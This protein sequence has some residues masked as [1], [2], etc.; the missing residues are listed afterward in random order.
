MTDVV[1]CRSTG[2]QSYESRLAARK[3]QAAI[4]A[5]PSRGKGRVAGSQT[6]EAY[7]CN[8]CGLYHLGRARVV[9]KPAAA[10]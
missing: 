6:I 2:K 1:Y 7:R 4:R 9:G 8:A 10:A 3:A 5:R